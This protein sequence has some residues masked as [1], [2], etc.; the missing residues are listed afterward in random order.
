[1]EI[2]HLHANTEFPIWYNPETKKMQ[3]N[4]NSN[5]KK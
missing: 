3:V 2:G 1:M 4:S 5:N